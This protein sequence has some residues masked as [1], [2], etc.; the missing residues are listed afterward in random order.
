M[1]YIPSIENLGASF[2][3]SIFFLTLPAQHFPGLGQ[4][5]FTLLY[6][7]HATCRSPGL[8]RLRA[9]TRTSLKRNSYFKVSRYL[10]TLG[11]S[12]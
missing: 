2:S 7:M 10:S 3:S 5:T 11:T 6:L 8:C 12:S 9:L 1:R 4:P